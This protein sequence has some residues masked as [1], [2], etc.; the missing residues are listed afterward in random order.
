ML[1][2]PTEKKAAI[3]TGLAALADE[4]AAIAEKLK[5]NQLTSPSADLKRDVVT[6]SKNEVLFVKLE[7]SG[8]RVV[9]TAGYE[10]Q[11]EQ[12]GPNTEL[13]SPNEERW[14]ELA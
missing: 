5:R 9:D 2:L 7:H 3:V 11:Q 6:R 14:R 1:V 4:R 13:L 10:K 12:L 8:R